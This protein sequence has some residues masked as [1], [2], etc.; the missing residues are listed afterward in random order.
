MPRL[1]TL[2]LSSAATG[3]KKHRRAGS[4]DGDST[5]RWRKKRERERENKRDEG[6]QGQPKAV[7]LS[8]NRREPLASSPRPRQS[9]G[10]YK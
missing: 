10:I 7:D 4:R 2:A 5:R 8:Y 6:D 3:E 9:L 1:P